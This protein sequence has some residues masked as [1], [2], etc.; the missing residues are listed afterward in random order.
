M[1]PFPKKPLPGRVSVAG[2]SQT[3]LELHEER[4][5]L[6]VSFK[7]GNQPDLFKERK[8]PFTPTHSPNPTFTA[9][10]EVILTFEGQTWNQSDIDVGLH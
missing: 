10:L 7:S 3:F 9:P 4:S 8:K 2:R 6:D 5:N 1:I